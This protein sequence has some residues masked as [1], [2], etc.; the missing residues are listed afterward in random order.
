[1]KT[2]VILISS[3][4]Y[5]INDEGKLPARPVWDKAMITKLCQGKTILCS[6]NTDATIPN[7]IRSKAKAVVT[8]PTLDWDVNF[9][10]STFTEQSDIFIVVK[11]QLP[12]LGGKRFKTD[13]LEAN[14]WRCY[15]TLEFDLWIHN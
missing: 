13:I 14:Y 7:S 9:G 6:R 5:Y 15:S 4:G 2:S 10:I 1:M 8:D 3:D 11:S 12:C